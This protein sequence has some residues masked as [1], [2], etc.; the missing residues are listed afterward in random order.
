MSGDQ[1]A[2]GAFQVLDLTQGVGQYA[3]RLLADLG[4]DVIRIEPR[5][6]GP[7]RQA[8]PFAGD[9][10]DPDRSLPFIHFNTNKRSIALDLA[11]AADRRTLLQLVAGADAV[12]EDG[13]P[14]SLAT[15]GL[16]YRDLERVNPA[17]VVTSVTPFG[18]TG[19]HAHWQGN[20]LIAQAMSDWL[21]NVGDEG[22]QPCAGPS[23]PS[24][25][26]G[27]THAALGTLIALYSRQT[28]GVGQHID[29]SVQEAM[30]TSSS[31]MP[32]GRFSA[33]T[34]V[35]R[36]FGS[37]TNLAGV[38]CY[39]CSD[40]YVVMNIHFAHLWKRL[41]EWIDHPVLNDPYWLSMTARHESADVA[42]EIIKEFTFSMTTNAFLTGARKLGLPVAPVNTFTEVG[43]SEQLAAR[44]WFQDLAHPSLGVVRMPGF[45]WALSETSPRFTRPA[46]LVDEH[47]DEIMREVGHRKPSSPAKAVHD[48]PVRPPLDGIRV[49]DLTRAWAGPFCTRLLA[50][51]GAEVIK[52][53]S[54][55]FDTQR[56]G[57]AGTYTELNRNKL[58]IT[59]DLHS[60]EGQELIK[61]LAEKSD[62]LVNNYRPGTLERFN[63]GYDVLRK[64]N[65]NIVVLSMPGYGSTGPGREYASHGAQLMADSGM[66]YIW[67]HPDT[68]MEMRGK[69]SIPDFLGGAQGALVVMAALHARNVIGG[70]QEVEIAQSEAL[71][72]ALGVGLLDST[73]N[74]RDWQ[75]AGNRKSYAAPHDLYP[76]HGRDSFCAVVCATDDQWRVLAKAIGRPA[77]AEDAR[78][79]TL[80]DR[81]ANIDEMDG[82]IGAWTQERSPRQVMYE[83]QKAGVPSSAVQSG[84]D[85][86][87]DVHLRERQFVVPVDDPESGP[88]DVAGLTA[89]LS[90]TPGR[91]QMAGRPVFGGANDYVFNTLLGLTPD[92]RQRL[93]DVGAIA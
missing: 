14:G 71:A 63:L 13:A 23:D 59:V 9:V 43:R 7:A 12:I 69:V 31:A 42:E 86:Y 76:C 41:V 87:F 6:G 1:T 81:I 29:V 50:D 21:F 27:G 57:R 53:E 58:S 83:L 74:G 79:A 89:H 70:G 47:R 91:Q 8:A 34:Q 18:Q 11:D 61:S 56:E 75:P 49:I 39:Q 25:H 90:V 20:D 2:L 17:I 66:Y 36:R 22:D 60:A 64:V 45:P 40:G 26:I 37:D 54:G 78:F 67:G 80:V 72:A 32:I 52:V 38:N 35:M 93:E 10:P 3:T 33:A 30:I 68:P 55:L 48:A 28:N 19:P 73:V 85:V 65:P 51:Y 77:L 4:V 82:I 16:G 46:P 24:V 84:E 15:L 62:V 5:G 92:E 88:M 44:D